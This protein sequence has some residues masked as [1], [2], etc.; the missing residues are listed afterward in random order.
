[1]HSGLLVW[2]SDYV[3]EPVILQHMRYSFSV[4]RSEGGFEIFA[5]KD[6]VMCEVCR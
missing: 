2:G 4:V 1:M 6:D 3:A 5:I